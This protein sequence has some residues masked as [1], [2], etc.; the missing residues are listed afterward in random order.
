MCFLI[1][2]GE[3]SVC[4]CVCANVCHSCCRCL[5]DASLLGCDLYSDRLEEL[6]EGGASHTDLDGRG[7]HHLALVLAVRGGAFRRVLP[8][9]VRL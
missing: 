3:Q 8:G 9:R 7:H 6:K 4:M 2:R 5:L 1:E